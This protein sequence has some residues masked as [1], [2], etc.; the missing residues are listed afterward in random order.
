MEADQPAT[1]RVT[2][3]GPFEHHD[4][5]VDGWRVPLLHAELV[6]GDR[7]LLVV[8]QRIAMEFT[9]DEAERVV[10]FVA[11]AVAVA[12]GYG[13]HPRADAEPPL[14]RLPY[15]RPMRTTGLLDD[16]A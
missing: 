12:L 16:A 11:D 10:P 9:T 8:D 6:D 3:P 5:V 7:V 15:P 13:A 4:V 1:F 14:Q 2:F